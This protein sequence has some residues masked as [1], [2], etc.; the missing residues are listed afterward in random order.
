MSVLKKLSKFLDLLGENTYY[1][2]GNF[3]IATYFEQTGTRIGNAYVHVSKDEFNYFRIE[4]SRI[5]A[6]K[7]EM[8]YSPFRRGL[9][10]L[11]W[12]SK[13]IHRG[14]EIEVKSLIRTHWFPLGNGSLYREEVI[15]YIELTF[16]IPR[17]PSVQMLLELIFR[18]F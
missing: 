9:H 17:E 4:I 12:K 3:R 10:C 16:F 13:F 18:Y 8:N 14:I 15:Q 6:Y 1:Q 7:S 2:R 5:I 11:C